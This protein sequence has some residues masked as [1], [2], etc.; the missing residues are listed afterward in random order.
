MLTGLIVSSTLAM[1]VGGYLV[2][3]WFR[4]FGPEVLES[5]QPALCSALIGLG[6]AG[7]N[8]VL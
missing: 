7:L 8:A 4:L 1:M 6:L 3:G 5:I 2:A